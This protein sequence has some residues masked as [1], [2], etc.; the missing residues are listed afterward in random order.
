MTDPNTSQIDV[1]RWVVFGVAFL[2]VS[3]GV[4]FLWL[5]LVS[6]SDGARFEPG[7]P[8]WERSGLVVTPLI[9]DANGLRLGD[10]VTAVDGRSM[11]SWAQDLFDLR[12]PRPRWELGDRVNYTV[13]RDGESLEVSVTLVP[14]PFGAI[15]RKNWG[16]I[17]FALVSQ[18]IAIFV[19]FRAP[20]ELAARVLLLWASGIMSA[21]TW[22]LGLQIS[23]LVGATGF[24]LFQATAFIGYM[25]F[26]IAGL[27]FALIFPRVMP[28]IVKYPWVVPLIYLAPYVLILGYVVGT[29]PGATNTLAWL[30]GWWEVNGLLSA[31]YLTLMFI[32]VTWGYLTNRDANARRRSRLVM[33]AALISG[34]GGLA[35]WLLP[36]FVVG[37]QIISANAMGLL[38]LPF[39]I[40]IALAI[41]RHQLFDID[42][43][44]NRTLVYGT[45]TAITMGIYVFIVGY[46]GNMFQARDKSIIAFLA[47]G[48]VAVV[49]HPLRERLQ[50]FVN[51]VMYG[52]RDDP[53]KVLSRLGQRL[54][55][56]IA[57][58]AVMPTIVETIAQTLKL[59]YVALAIKQGEDIDIAA[60]Y[61]HPI[62]DLF[63]LPLIYQTEPIGQLIVAPR[64]VDEA[65]TSAEERLLEDIALQAGVAVHAVRL[66]DDLQRSRERLVTT[67]EE[68][69]RRLRRD[70]HDGL[71]PE[72][73]SLTLKL[74]AARNILKHDPPAVDQML[75]E[76]KTQTQDAIN[77][78]RRLVYELRP[79]ALDELG[80]LS[81]IQEYIA[82][83]LALDDTSSHNTF[84]ISMEAP[85]HLPPL[86]AAVEVAAYRIVL[87]ALTNFARHAQASNCVIRFS[88]TDELEIEVVDDGIGLQ[89]N[90][91]AGVGL[92]SMRERASE[93]GGSCTIETLKNQG[94]RVYA[95]LPLAIREE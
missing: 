75:L 16:P 49:F 35:L 38:V 56:T 86:T 41:L 26:W 55:T 14:Y 20:G 32:T 10:T 90:A 39:P 81:A 30:G 74:D 66:T 5:H 11:E 62:G 31:L 9:D 52:E 63:Q 8:V 48:L 87:E 17:L 61:G 12:T 64:A 54:E 85:D 22:S 70:L 7:Q 59:P 72:L 21:T 60:S 4:T 89:T 65:F 13:L 50:R 37:R 19:F 15:L 92:T 33:F 88:V 73:A 34:G 82:G 78:V 80:L 68:E 84:L 76:L 57:P 94:T 18:L 46:L 93:L 29:L 51:R 1:G 25:L 58:E 79:P 45:L 77:E 36:P 6:P 71:G 42:L 47:T 23:D 95:R 3:L 91:R 44:I 53:Y 69:R 2:I 28:L 83:G 67:R 43:V 24:W 40:A 27:H